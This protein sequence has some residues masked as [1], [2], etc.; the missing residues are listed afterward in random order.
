MYSKVPNCK[1][2]P[3]SL[4]HYQKDGPI[5]RDLTQKYFATYALPSPTTPSETHGTELRGLTFLQF[6]GLIISHLF[7]MHD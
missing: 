5:E 6:Y 2:V 3:I 1:S 7:Y 4:S